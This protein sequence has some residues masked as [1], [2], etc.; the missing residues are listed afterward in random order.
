MRYDHHMADRQA[1]DLYGADLHEAD[2]QGVDLQGADRQL[3]DLQL[4]DLQLA[5]LQL[6][7][8]RH[9]ATQPNL[10]GQRC[11]GDLDVPLTDIGRAQAR[12][13]GQ[14]IAQMQASKGL[15]VGLI[16]SSGLQRTDETAAIL[17]QQLGGARVIVLRGFVERHLGQWNRRS[18]SETEP[19]IAG[20]LTPP[21]GESNTDFLARITSA[22][23][24]LLPHWPLAP[25]RPLVV[26]SRGVGRALGELTG[27]PG[28]THLANG[29][30]D[31]FDLARCVGLA[32]NPETAESMA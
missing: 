25:Q 26:A 3:A 1:V 13:A 17:A 16:V 23:H 2:L 8:V 6:A 32:A 31:C 12:A 22:V 24:S 27:R 29:Q 7:F 10:D 19:W 9:G 18:L 4:A 11:G 21:G 14:H 5:D 20:G 15:R 28:R 30:V